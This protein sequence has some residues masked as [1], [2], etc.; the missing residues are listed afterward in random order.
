[1]G[2]KPKAESDTG[3]IWMIGDHIVRG[4]GVGVLVGRSRGDL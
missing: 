3:M 4:G 1:M 2:E